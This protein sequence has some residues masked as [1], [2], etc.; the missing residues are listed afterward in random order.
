MKKQRYRRI[1]LI[2]IQEGGAAR[3]RWHWIG[4]VVSILGLLATILR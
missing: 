4:L 3:L 1:T 2:E